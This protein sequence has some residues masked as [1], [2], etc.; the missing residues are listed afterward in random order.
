ML[1]QIIKD[2]DKGTTENA[3]RLIKLEEK[4]T[5]INQ[6]YKIK[7]IEINYYKLDSEITLKKSGMI[8]TQFKISSNQKEVLSKGELEKAFTKR[9]QDL[10]DI[11]IDIK[12]NALYSK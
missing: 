7:D 12:S 6:K 10:Q 3:V 9:I 1:E 4:A 11:L 5:K 2:I 8:L